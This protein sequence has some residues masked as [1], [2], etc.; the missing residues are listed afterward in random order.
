MVDICLVAGLNVLLCLP[1]SLVLLNSNINTYSS[2]RGRRIDL[3]STEHGVVEVSCV[4]GGARS[5]DSCGAIVLALLVL[6][7]IAAEE[8][9]ESRNDNG[10]VADSQG[11]T[12]LE[13]TNNSLPHAG[14]S[15]DEDGVGESSDGGGDGTGENGDQ[16]ETNG[17]GDTNVSENPEGSNDQENVR[18]GFG[19]RRDA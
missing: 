5:S 15:N 11:D 19:W 12:S 2:R 1:V 7:W 13:S 6:L 9:S 17:G 10:E 16:P 8:T 4:F 3:E 18:K 14:E